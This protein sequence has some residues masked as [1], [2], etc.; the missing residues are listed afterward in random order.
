MPYKTSEVLKYNKEK[1]LKVLRE[2]MNAEKWLFC[3]MEILEN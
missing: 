2:Q 3:K 1:L